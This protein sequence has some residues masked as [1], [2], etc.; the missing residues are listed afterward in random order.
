MT[1]G[2][3]LEDLFR[4]VTDSRQFDALLLESLSGTLQL[5]QLPFTERSPV[6]GT[7]EEKYGATSSFQC[8]QAL[9]SAELVAN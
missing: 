7:E 5:D 4:V 2:K 1:V 3:K 9:R 8:V 6:G